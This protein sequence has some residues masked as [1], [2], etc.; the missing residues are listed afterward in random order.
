MIKNP[1]YFNITTKS[2]SCN[3][4]LELKD[5][6]PNV[7]YLN[8]KP[9][10][11][12]ITTRSFSC[13]AMLEMKDIRTN[14]LKKLFKESIETS[15]TN[16]S[17]D[18]ALKEKVKASDEKKDNLHSP[19]IQEHRQDL[20]AMEEDLLAAKLALSAINKEIS[21]KPATKQ[22]IEER[23]YINTQYRDFFEDQD[24]YEQMEG[25]DSLV[26][27]RLLTEDLIDCIKDEK[28][29]IQRKIQKFKSNKKSTKEKVI[30][31]SK[32]ETVPASKEEK[33]IPTSKE[34]T[35]PASSKSPTPTS[36]FI[37]DLPSEHN[38][39]DDIGED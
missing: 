5:L 26:M 22:E 35:V 10:Y 17:E 31:S 33:V 29:F 3:A 37:D 34:E 6:K 13:N 32:E 16:S 39:F 7:L 36:D 19:E 38:P 18:K 14:V 28:K 20:G 30:P 15:K 21:N 11:L 2:L 4:I 24:E 27:Q 9:S 8:K 23:K 1:F 12:N 25:E